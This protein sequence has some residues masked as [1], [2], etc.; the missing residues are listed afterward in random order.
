M[1]TLIH[2]VALWFLAVSTPLF[3]NDNLPL[4]ELGFV[5]A[6]PAFSKEKLTELLGE[7][8]QKIE[9]TDDRT[10]QIIGLIWHYEYLNTNEDG[11][12]YKSTE[13]DLIDDKVVNIIFSNSDVDEIETAA[14]TMECTPSC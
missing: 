12:Y 10:G 13:L 9:V 11:D 5:D 1:K 4:D 3:A 14:S 7:P 8:K 2:A 6:I